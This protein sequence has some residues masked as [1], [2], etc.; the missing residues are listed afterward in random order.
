[1]HLEGDNW[2]T[3]FDAYQRE[4]FR[5]ETRQSYGVESERDEYEHFL[6]TGRLDIPDS[7]QW[8]TR[9][10]HFRRSGRWIGRVHVLTRPLTDYLRYEFAVYDF[11]AAAGEDVRNLDV[12]G[13][14]RPDLR[15]KTSGFL[16]I[17]P[18]FSWTTT[19][20]AISYVVNF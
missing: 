6:A 11:I 5:L 10:R 17:A 16:M 20:K 9:V 1:V 19:T 14:S 7:D 12:T 8:L 3:F 18:L 15:G 13:K 2:R 4:A